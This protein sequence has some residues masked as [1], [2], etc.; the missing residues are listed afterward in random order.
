MRHLNRI[1][2]L[3]VILTAS[4]QLAVSKEE[5]ALQCVQPTG[6]TVFGG[7]TICAGSAGVTITLTGSQVGISYQLRNGGTNQGSPLAGTGSA[8]N[9]TN[10]TVAGNYTVLATNTT[11][12]CT[13]TMFSSATINVN[14]LPTAF[15]VGGGGA[16][17][18]GAPGVSITLSGSQTGVR[19]QLMNGSTPGPVQNGTGG[20]LTFTNQTTAGTYT[21]VATNNSTTCSKQMN[22]T[23]LIVVNPL[24]V[25]FNVGGGGATCASSNATI[26]LSGSESGVNYQLRIGGTNQGAPLAGTGSAISFSTPAVAGNYTV[27]ATNAS[28]GCARAMS[29][30]AMVTLIPAPTAFNV[31]GGGTICSGAA[32]VTITLSGSQTGV[33]YQLINGTANQGSPVNGTGGVLNFT[34]QTVAGNYTIVATRTSTGCSQTMTGSATVTVNSL[35]ALFTVGGSGAICSGS[36]TSVSLSGSQT[37]VN[38]QLVLGTTNQGAPIAGTGSALSFPNL[39]SAG[40]YTVVA[41][42]TSTGCKQT[43]T[44]NAVIS[45]NPLPTSF[46][47]GGGGAIC[48]PGIGVTITL[49]GSQTGVNYQLMMGTASVGSA[50]PGNGSTINFPNQ[51]AIGTY[52]V[53]ATTTGTGCQRT[54]TG[55]A[56]VTSNLP[57]AFTVSGGGTICSG[58]STTITLSGSQAGV[59]YQLVLGTTNQGTPI[60]GTGS[61]LTFANETLAGT[62][63]VVATNATTGCTQAMTGNATITTNAQPTVFNVSGGG[64]IC[65]GANATISLSGSETGVNYQLVLGAT[66]QGTPIAGTGSALTFANETAAGTYTV[67]ATNATTGCTQAMTGNATITTN[68]Q[69]TVFNVSGGGA[70]C[71]GANTIITLSGSQAGVNYQLVLG[72]TNQGTPVAGTGSALTF[73]N[74]T[75]AG[76]YT[77]VA[78]NAT[79]GCTQAMTGNATITTNA[80]PIVFNVS[81]GGAICSGANT[82]ITLSGSESGV[83]YQ[84]V[85]GTTNQGTPIAG[86]GSALTFANETAAGTYTVVATNATTGC[87]Q[88]MTGSVLITINEL[89]DTFTVVGGG[90][91]CTSDSPVP[92]T[93]SG[94]K[95]KVKYQLQI[96]GISNGT[97]LSGTGHVLSWP[98][99]TS[100]GTYT[101][102]ATD[103][104]SQC[105]RTMTDSA[106]VTVYPLPTKYSLVCGNQSPLI[107]QGSEVGVNYQLRLKG[108]NIGGAISGTGKTIRWPAQTK[109]GTYTV[110]ATNASSGCTDYMANTTNVTDQKIPEAVKVNRR[111][112]LPTAPVERQFMLSSLHQG[113]TTEIFQAPPCLDGNYYVGFQLYYDLGDRQTKT[114]WVSQLTLTIFHGEDSLTSLPLQVNMKDQVFISTEFYDSLV[115]CGED[116]RF[117]VT[118]KVNVGTVPEDNVYLKVLL[119]KSA[120]TTAAQ[121]SSL[122]TLSAISTDA[123]DPSSELLLNCDYTVT[124]T[125]LSWNYIGTGVME[126][127]IEWVFIDSL[128]N[129]TGRSAQEAFQFKEPVRIT[130]AGLQY[131]HL[132]FYPRGTIWY[133]ARAVG[134]DPQYPDHRIQGEWFYSPCESI[135]VLNPQPDKSWQQQTV[136]AEEGKYKKVLHYFDGSMRERQSQTNL[137]TEGVTLVGESLYDFE[138]RKSVDI[139]P[140]PSVDATLT[141]KAS[142][143]IFQAND[144][145]VSSNTSATRNKFH[146]DNYRLENSVLSSQSG[147]GQYYSSASVSNSVHKDYIPDAQGYAYSQTEYTNDGTG[148]IRRQAGVGQTFRT[149]G[150]HTTR[151]FYGA[152]APTELIRLFGSNVGVASHYKKNMVVDANGQTSVTYLDQEGR[153]IATALA[154]D[155]PSNVDALDSYKKLDPAPITVDVSPKNTFINGSWIVTHS[156]LNAIPNTPFS[157]KYKMAALA[158]QVDTLGCKACVYDL[159]FTLTDPDGTPLDLSSVPGNQSPD[160]LSYLRSGLTAASCTDSLTVKDVQ[161]DVLLAQAGDYTITK[162]LTPQELS[163]DVMKDIVSQDSSTQKQ[164]QQIQAGYTAD[165]NDCAI[166]SETCP[167]AEQAIQDA[168]QETTTQDCENIY[169]QI[170]ADLNSQHSDNPDYQPTVGEITAHA[171]NCQYELCLKDAKSESFEKQMSRYA[172]WPAAVSAGYSNPIDIDPFFNDASLSGFSYKSAMQAKLNDVQVANVS[173]D[174]NNDGVPDGSRSVHGPIGQVTNPNN[175]SYYI[176]ANGNPDPVNGKHVLYMDLMSQRSQ[177]GESAYQTQV[178][179]QRWQLFRSFYDEAKRKI[180]LT[181]YQNCAPAVQ[182]LQATDN[183]P[184]T[185]DAIT[186]YGNDN[187]VSAIPSNEEVASSLYSIKSACNKTFSAADSTVI[188]KHLFYYFANKPSNF[189]RLIIKTDVVSDSSLLQI[190]PI[191]QKY[192]CTL[193]SVA[194]VDPVNCANEKTVTIP[195]KVRPPHKITQMPSSMLM[196]ARLSSLESTAGL[197]ESSFSSKINKTQTSQSGISPRKMFADTIEKRMKH[198]LHANLKLAGGMKQGA[199]H[200]TKKDTTASSKNKTKKTDAKK[201]I[202]HKRSLNSAKLKDSLHNAHLNK[203][204]ITN[205]PK[206]KDSLRTVRMNEIKNLVSN[207]IDSKENQKTASQRQSVQAMSLLST[208]SAPLPTQAEYNALINLYYS[209]LGWGHWTHSEGWDTADRNVIEDVS[210]WYGVTTDDQGHVIALDVSHNFLRGSIPSEIGG[211]TY[212]K[213]MNLGFNAWLYGSVVPTEIG[214]LTNLE[215]LDLTDTGIFSIPS[216]IGSLSNLKYLYLGEN[217]LQSIPN[218][219]GNI[220]PLV[221]LN[222]SGSNLNSIPASIGNLSSLQELYVAQNYLT[223]LPAAIGQ[224]SE[225]RVLDLSWNSFTSLP[226]SLFNN[227]SS[228]QTLSINRNQSQLILPPLGNLSN[229]KTLEASQSQLTKMPVGLSSLINL[230]KLDFSYNS[231]NDS[232]PDDFGNLHK[233]KLLNIYDAGLKGGLPTSMGGLDSLTDVNLSYN[234]MTGPI[235]PTI[236]QLTKLTNLDLYY[237]AISG[238][239]PAGLG[240]LVNLQVLSIARNQLSGPIPPELGNLV[241]LQEL[242][243]WDNQL[244]GSIPAQLGGMTSLNSLGLANNQLSGSIPAGLSGMTGLSS[245]ELAQ[246]QLSGN[247]PPDFGDLSQTVQILLLSDNQLSGPIPNSFASYDASTYWITLEN[248]KFTFSDFIYVLDSG[249]WGDGCGGDGEGGGGPCF[250]YSPQ[251][252]ID[253]VK[254]IAA[255][256]GQPLIL[257]TSID[258]TT[259]PSSLYQW[260]KY[261]DGNNDIPLNDFPTTFNYADT[262]PALAQADDGS[263]YYYTITND[264]APDLILTSN[265][266]TL[267]VTA[268]GETG[269]CGS[270]LAEEYHALMDLYAATNGAEWKNNTG[271]RDANPSVVQ[272]VQ[273]WYGVQTDATGHV[274]VLD[275]DGIIDWGNYT[276]N[277]GYQV[278]PGNNLSGTIPLSIGKLKCLTGLNF[279]GNQLTGTIPS[280]VGQLT[281]LQWLIFSFNQLSGSIPSSIWNLTKLVAFYA[282]SNRLTGGIPPEVGNLTNLWAIQLMDNYLTGPI[283]KEF[284]NLKNMQYFHL[285]DNNFTGAIPPELGSMTNCV[286]FGLHRNQLT[287]TIPPELGNL[288]NVAVIYLGKNQLTGSVP[289]SLGNLP[290]LFQ[291]YL[292]SCS[293]SGPIPTSIGDKL[294]FNANRYGVPGYLGIAANK[295][296]F[297]DILPIKHQLQASGTFPFVQVPGHQIWFLI[298]QS[299]SALGIVQHQIT[300]PSFDDTP[301]DSVDVRQFRSVAA[302]DTVTLTAAID[303]TTSP[304]SLYQWFNNGIAVTNPSTSGYTLS[305]PNIST[306]DAGNYYYKITNPDVADLTLTSRLQPLQVIGASMNT[307]LEYDTNNSTLQQFTVTVDWNQQIQQCM[308]RTAQAD[309]ILTQYAISKLL[310]IQV[311]NLYNKYSTLCAQ[312]VTE[313]LTYTYVSKEYHYTLYYYDQAGNLV[314]TV[315]PKGVVPLTPQQVASSMAGPKTYLLN[316]YYSK[317]GSLLSSVTDTLGVTREMVVVDTAKSTQGV[318]LEDTARSV[319]PG[320]KYILK[321]RGY[322]TRD[323][324]GAIPYLFVASGDK[325]LAWQNVQIPFGANNENWVSQE[326]II[327]DSV[328]S[329]KYGVLWKSGTSL[330]PGEGWGE[331]DTLFIR[332]AQLIHEGN[333]I[334]PEHT[335][336]TRYQYNSINQLVSQQT[337]DAGNSDFFYNNK[338]QLKLSQNAQQAIDKKFS[339]T[340]YDEQGRIVEVGEVDGQWTMDHGQGSAIL[341][342][343]IN[344]LGFPMANAYSLKDVTL[345]HYDEPSIVLTREGGLTQENLRS[346]VSF[347][348]VTDATR[349][350]TVRTYYSYDIHGNVKSLQQSLPNLAPRRTDYV[351]DLVSDKVNYVFYQFGKS[352]QFVHRYQYDADNRI[353]EVLTSSDRFI[354]NKEVNY[355]YYSHGPLARTELGQYR[356]QGMDYYYTLQGWIKG[357]NMPYAG[358]PG[359]DSKPTTANATV[360]KDVFA[361]SLGYFQNDYAP[362]TAAMTTVDSRDQLWTRSLENINHTGLYNGNISWMETDL[363]AIASAK[364]DRTKG[365]QAMMYRYDQLHR[366]VKSRSLTN[367]SATNGFTVRPTTSAYDEDYSYDPNGNILTLNRN[368]EAATLKDDFDYKYYDKT[369]RLEQHKTN[370]GLY[371]YDAIGNL[372]NDGNEGTRIS[373]TPYGKVRTVHKGDSVTV[374]YRYDAVGNRIE[375]RI[376]KLDTIL[377]TRYLRDVRGTVMTIYKD[378]TAFEIPIYGAS[379]LGQYKGGVNEGNRVLGRRNYELSNHLGNVISVITDNVGMNADSVWATIVSSSDYYPF[380]LEMKGRTL[381]DSIYRYGFNAKEKDDVFGS[382]TDY[383]YGFRIYSPEIAKFLSVDPLTKK[384]PY[385]SPYQFAGDT[386]IMAQDIDGL[387]PDKQVNTNEAPTQTNEA[388]TQGQGQNPQLNLNSLNK[389][390]NFTGLSVQQLRQQVRQQYP[391]LEP[392]QVNITAGVALESAYKNFSKQPG[393]SENFLTNI[394]S[395]P[396]IRSVRPDLVHGT[397]VRGANAKELFFPYG[398]YIEVKASQ[399]PLTLQTSNNQIEGYLNKLPY[400]TTLDLK[401]TSGS[402]KAASLTFVVPYGAKVGGDILKKATSAGVNVYVSYAFQNIQNGNVVFSDPKR[403]NNISKE[404]PYVNGGSIEGVKLNLKGSLRFRTDNTTNDSP[405]D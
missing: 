400:S 146:Y 142:F 125:N 62:Y 180:K 160:G 337:P 385:Y 230:E 213:S 288:Q 286:S 219:I 98:N 197:S 66:N 217:S 369:N 3:L 226:S 8:L 326:F 39:V 281:N 295:F 398:G 298:K 34:N 16:I 255:P 21:I 266:Q 198:G 113:D 269:G 249:Y 42:N 330:S 378:T 370:G 124:Q 374:N 93:L 401:Y 32:G 44:G 178:D 373:W 179:A 273:G 45:I 153:T 94:S 208:A 368:D 237:N 192:G 252:T 340:R 128:D 331:A 274:T 182:A 338:G 31:T 181:A 277:D 351:Y 109:A 29:G 392:W 201:F 308:E 89:P 382:S 306:L 346:R 270:T 314:Q 242:A 279:G 108:N 377:I 309:S 104:V 349:P 28:T 122:R 176:D 84:L 376:V 275:L 348:E 173:Y 99:N 37:G 149:D 403:L 311:T 43:M 225:L 212:L 78:T 103:S 65:S 405:N 24:P 336:V 126:Y 283:P 79:T 33:T 372:I 231:F 188:S 390:P 7:G 73:A 355:S 379:R 47:V 196:E 170:V 233:L 211:L 263:Q 389:N 41:M 190:Q 271:W 364:A 299:P 119:Y 58:A 345:T 257:T 20:A 183:L 297:S 366:I 384:Y 350:D 243:L 96:N 144:T 17:C 117:M 205:S 341:N 203:T 46:T 138:G 101:V 130:T 14:P 329:I 91:Y 177:L 70:I 291:L 165:P 107:L 234:Q 301:Q 227:L 206:L 220:T 333:V 106:V 5:K 276:N 163:F 68:A 140:V 184:T 38:Y 356:V 200:H 216:S 132:I 123:F 83:N 272:S 50:V 251:A 86:T 59:N 134:Y 236:G 343:S 387:E 195:W 111:G 202:K 307:C 339:Y 302:G 194:V 207:K 248:N 247:L 293:F 133:R 135:V 155:N 174:S 67:V 77:V 323:S 6:F 290:R 310:D 105:N 171:L 137:S 162:T 71:S 12:G 268:G 27:F 166:C 95:K 284:G 316:Q 296:T 357:V 49:S 262:I 15:N 240:S 305:L 325:I 186:A 324:V 209:T 360:G 223:S 102:I 151:H 13:R 375:K 381:N 81:G 193:D 82:T 69:P 87:K 287:G 292:D 169:N 304:S 172:N 383:D 53:V 352:D 246:N 335:L 221:V 100:G 353:T 380:G 191:L 367:Y 11:T 159:M 235:P 317:N 97:P 64:A 60:A 141:F 342:D 258:R 74:E 328:T 199:H 92:V 232:L 136:F 51:N 313:K 244:S 22:G 320:E 361:Y 88:T 362:I 55:S 152:A 259:D 204:K 395:F 210:G 319:I 278:Y 332:Q 80:Q 52:T 404:M 294:A 399:N 147:T 72:A 285:Y 228:L 261:V 175:T 397:T 148:R 267:S 250:T 229:L 1:I 56:N 63:A 312:N 239:L 322:A 238:S 396:Y 118:Q 354:W 327:P 187:G 318:L 129:F 54:M 2:L 157:F 222:L 131:S 386:P 76:T 218:E 120:T 154:G 9:F 358:D 143:N 321:V 393:N 394:S 388:S 245:L 116:Y 280:E 35:P 365:M 158:S 110:K 161:I 26:T 36:N 150:D 121:A 75:V 127:D 241:N 282:E 256:A 315:P 344:S 139:L 168:I 19:Y 40:T 303:R 253:S 164:I 18:N 4:N 85:L 145:T 23:A 359:D 185:P 114:N 30:S 300:T 264:G 391:S 48:T 402:Q 167:E 115:S 189:F 57:T 334:L 214:L 61:A 112:V 260:F 289:E 156:I 265:L 90:N 254:T 347:V 224:L 215:T 25:V 363:S 10:Q 371:Q